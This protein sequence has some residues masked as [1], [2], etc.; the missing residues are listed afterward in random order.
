MTIYQKITEIFSCSHL[1]QYAKFIAFIYRRS[2]QLE[3]QIYSNK[4]CREKHRKKTTFRCQL[5]ETRNVL[6][7]MS[8]WAHTKSKVQSKVERMPYS[9]RVQ[10]VATTLPC[11]PHV[12]VGRCD[13]HSHEEINGPATSPSQI[14]NGGSTQLFYTLLGSM[15]N[16]EQLLGIKALKCYFILLLISHLF[17]TGL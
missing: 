5:D 17:Q 6:R 12:S 10:D 7:E 8:N 4:N 13:A 1:Y 11:F 9:S 16:S 14:L 15:E 2:I 3:D